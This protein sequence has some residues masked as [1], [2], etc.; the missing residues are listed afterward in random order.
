VGLALTVAM[1]PVRLR[2]TKSVI[3]ASLITIW[4]RWFLPMAVSVAV[5]DTDSAS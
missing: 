2:A 5:R 1:V 4:L 3:S